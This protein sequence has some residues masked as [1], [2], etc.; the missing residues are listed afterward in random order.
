VI[1]ERHKPRI[2][3]KLNDDVTTAEITEPVRQVSDLDRTGTP[4]ASSRSAVKFA[5]AA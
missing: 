2:V 5:Y 4:R 1:K 3:I